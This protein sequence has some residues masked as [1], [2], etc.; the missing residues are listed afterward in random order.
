MSALRRTSKGLYDQLK[1]SDASLIEAERQQGELWK[2]V[3]EC[4]HRKK[5]KQLENMIWDAHS[6]L[7]DPEEV[8]DFLVFK[9]GEDETIIID[10]MRKYV[11]R[12]VIEYMLF[13]L[14]DPDDTYD[15]GDYPCRASN[16]ALRKR[17]YHER[18]ECW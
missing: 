16:E 11:S 14:S 5:Q 13:N 12:A 7:T 4:I 2:Q 18:Y 8:P 15:P 6:E 17:L 1:P 3:E 10:E 9:D